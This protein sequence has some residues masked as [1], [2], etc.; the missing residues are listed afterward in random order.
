MMVVIYVAW[1]CIGASNRSPKT[2]IEIRLVIG[3][4]GGICPDGFV[5]PAQR[6]DGIDSQKSEMDLVATA[7]AQMTTTELEVTRNSKSAV[8]AARSSGAEHV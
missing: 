1:I 7:M 2:G 3:F 4:G 8:G 6:W 5:W